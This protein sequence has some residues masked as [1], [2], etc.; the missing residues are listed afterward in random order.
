MGN[1]SIKTLKF[2]DFKVKGILEGG[3]TMT[4][5]LFDDKDLK[6]GD[7][8]ELINKDSGKEFTRAIIVSIKEKKLKD[9]EESDYEGHEKFENKEEIYEMCRHYYGDKVNPDS[10]V[11]IIKFKLI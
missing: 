4:W 8:L 6:E 5:R 1:R 11:K 9:I 7:E 2:R 10:I 3:K